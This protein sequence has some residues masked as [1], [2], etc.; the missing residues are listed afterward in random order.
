M[1]EGHRTVGGSQPPVAELV[2][3]LSIEQ[4]REV[5]C[6]AADR[7]YD[8]ERAV[9][10]VAAR[11]ND[12]L[13]VLRVEVDRGLRTRRFLPYRESSGWAHAARPVVEELRR[14]HQLAVC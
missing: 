6:S 7:H 3:S 4:I 5:V 11:A 8:V 14:R 9:R 10:L 12:D 13:A 2:E 1:V